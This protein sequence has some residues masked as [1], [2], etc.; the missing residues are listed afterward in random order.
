MDDT[1]AN[2]EVST[3]GGHFCKER[4]NLLETTAV[5]WC[6]LVHGRFFLITNDMHTGHSW[7]KCSC[8]VRSNQGEIEKQEKN[9]ADKGMGKKKKNLKN[10]T[11]GHMAT[12]PLC[13]PHVS[14]SRQSTAELVLY[15]DV[16]AV[17]NRHTS[18]QKYSRQIAE[19]AVEAGGFCAITRLSLSREDT[20]NH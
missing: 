5:S 16:T 15:N 14:S 18:F 11:P 2:G 6:I 12:L 19:C 3:R 13:L 8:I 7:Q 1:A 20:T 10:D 17:Y 4:C 9:N